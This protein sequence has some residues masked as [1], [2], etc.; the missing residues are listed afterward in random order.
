MIVT[1]Y[2]KTRKDGVV[3]NRTYSDEGLMIE[4]DGVEYS[5]AVDPAHLNREY[6]EVHGKYVKEPEDPEEVMTYV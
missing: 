5:E 2:F 1:E 6:T 3:L 4:R